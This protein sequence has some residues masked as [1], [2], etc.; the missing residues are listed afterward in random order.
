MEFETIIDIAIGVVTL[1][2]TVAGAL[3]TAWLFFRKK[4][5]IWWKP[6]KDGIE[7]AARIP[8][9]EKRIAE[10]TNE[11]A[12]VRADMTMLKLTV[13]ARSD[14]NSEVAEFDCDA[15]GK[16]IRVSRTYTRWLGVS[17]DELLGFNFLNFIHPDDR[18][19]VRAEWESCRRE[20]RTYDKRHRL[21]SAG[22]A[23]IAV[24]TIVN[25]IPY[26][27]PP[28]KSWIGSMRRL[29]GGG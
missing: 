18:E 11:I 27:P 13:Q 2:G 22:G 7:G 28:A 3:G 8:E 25:P 24:H 17:A 4:I 1:I 5:S 9:M 16:N 29:D 15:E 14:A 19:E 6:Y 26:A 12:G 20:H 23:V 21:V 10:S